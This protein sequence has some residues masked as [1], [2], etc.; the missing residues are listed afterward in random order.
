MVIS[1]KKREQIAKKMGFSEKEIFE[2]A[3]SAQKIN[4][5][6]IK[7]VSCLAVEAFEQEKAKTHDRWG[8]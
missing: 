2:N 1:K 6:R 4:E 3:R 7:T 5:E 8:S